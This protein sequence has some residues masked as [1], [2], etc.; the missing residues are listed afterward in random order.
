MRV[1]R[2]LAVAIFATLSGGFVLFAEQ[3]QRIG[4]DS[5]GGS[6]G[7]VVL[8]GASDR[9]AAGADL[10]IANRNLRLLIS[11]LNEK[12]TRDD[13]L[14]QHPQL[15]AIDQCCLDLGWRA[16]NTVGNALE[17]RD[18]AARNGYRSITLVTS[19]SHMPRAIAEFAH[20]MP[21]VTLHPHAAGARADATPWRL[22]LSQWRIIGFEY[23]KYVF[24]RLRMA[25]EPEP[26]RW[27]PGALRAEEPQDRSARR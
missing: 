2:I 8:T 14:A 3:T 25:L 19:A 13:M 17:A 27:L 10:V 7:V 22:D 9:I 21:A 18:W 15:R 16:M 11:G 24:S 26:G 12:V 23:A 20:A 1:R 6:D 4:N 5:S